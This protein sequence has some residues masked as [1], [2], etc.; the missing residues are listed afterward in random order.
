MP[1]SFLDHVMPGAF[2]NVPVAATF[3]VQP[4]SALLAPRDVVAKH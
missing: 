3:F 2:T 1:F 4:S